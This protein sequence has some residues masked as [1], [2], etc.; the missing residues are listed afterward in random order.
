[1]NESKPSLR[2]PRRLR[3]PALVAAAL[4]VRME[5]PVVTEASAQVSGRV[6]IEHTP[7]VQVEQLAREDCRFVGCGHGVSY[8]L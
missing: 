2:R 7:D 5:H 3:R 1:M 4:V 6:G 8:L